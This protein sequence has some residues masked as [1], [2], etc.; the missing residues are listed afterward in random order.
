MREKT[1]KT[2][3]VFNVVPNVL[4]LVSV[5]AQMMQFLVE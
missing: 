1:G 2:N 5:T 3:K 4:P